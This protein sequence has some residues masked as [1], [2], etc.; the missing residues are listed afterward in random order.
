MKDIISKILPTI[1]WV[2]LFWYSM[3]KDRSRYRNVVLL[4]LTGLSAL[5][6]IYSLFSSEVSGVLVLIT[7]VLVGLAFLTLPFFLFING[8]YMIKREGQSLGNLLSFFLGLILIAGE[9]SFF[10]WFFGLL[11]EPEL[12]VNMS[13]LVP[14]SPFFAF[15]GLSSG[16]L[17]VTFVS[18]LLYCLFLQIIPHR[19]DFDYVIIH[20]AGIKKDGTVTKLLA[21]RC[22]KAIEIYRKDPT[23]PYLV[24]SGGQGSDEV[25]SEAEAMR[26]YLISQGIPEDKILLE[27]KSKTTMENV[28]FSK[29]LIEK[30][31]GRKYTALVTSN[32][33]I[34]RAMRY[35]KRAQ[36]KAVGIGSRVAPYYY[37][38][39]LIREFVAVHKERKHLILFAIGYLLFV[40]P[41]I[42]I[43]L[44]A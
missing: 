26:K 1:F 19:R 8:L 18:F 27:D 7:M 44:A 30:R 43:M 12:G 11:V 21:D 29:N 41:V 42:V 22:D 40:S 31:L 14:Y 2:G 23:S 3:Y 6:F 32:Y 13:A 15:F 35:A 39:A 9:L 5:G 36:L 28:T 17:S 37:P 16:Y 4:L 34:Y 10:L 38:S 33:H 25:C 24:P 20:G